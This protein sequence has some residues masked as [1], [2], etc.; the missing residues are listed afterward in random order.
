MHELQFVRLALFAVPRKAKSVP[1]FFVF[2]PLRLSVPSL[3]SQ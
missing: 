1:D 2:S 3:N